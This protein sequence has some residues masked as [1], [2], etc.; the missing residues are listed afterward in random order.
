ML[1]ILRTIRN[2]Y[3]SEKTE[4]FCVLKQVKVRQ[5]HYRPGVAQ[6]VPRS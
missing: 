4:K 2:M 5:S 6:K 3:L 1:L